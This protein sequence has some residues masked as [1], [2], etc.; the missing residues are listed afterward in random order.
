MMRFISRLLLGLCG[1]TSP[2]VVLGMFV[3]LS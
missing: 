3:R 2:V 1:V